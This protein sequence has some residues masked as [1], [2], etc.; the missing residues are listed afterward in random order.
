MKNKQKIIVVLGPTAAGKSDL[1]V[2][3]AKDFDGEI[4]SADSRQIYKGLDIASNKISKNEMQDVPHHLLDIVNPDQDYSLYNW[5]QGAFEAIK[6]ILTKNK[7]PIIAGGTGLYICSVIQNYDMHPDK[8]SLRECPYDF[9]VLGIDPEREKLYTKINKRVDKMLDDGSIDE[10]KK[11]YKKYTNKKLPA[12]TGIGYKQIIEYLDEKISLEEAIDKIK[13]STRN[14][15]KRQMTWW[16][17]MEK[18]GIKIHWN[19]NSQEIKKLL[20]NFLK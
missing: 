6:K 12:L 11:I 2:Q 20:A 1:A 5:Q 4:I 18:Q 19:Q 3:I 14:Y 10:V 7:I 17:R 8:P 15:A 9:V 16:R 13:Q